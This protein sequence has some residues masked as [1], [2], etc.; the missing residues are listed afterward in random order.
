MK[1]KEFE[2][3]YEYQSKDSKNR[4]KESLFE[5]DNEDS[6]GNIVDKGLSFVPRAIRFKKAK[7]VMKRALN[8]YYL[9][10]VNLIRKFDRSMKVVGDKIEIKYKDLLENKISPLITEEKVEQTI[11]LLESFAEDLKQGQKTHLDKLNQSIETVLG[12]YTQSIEK[13]IES[14]GFVFNVELSEKGKGELSAKWNELVAIKKMKIDQKI[15]DLINSPGIGKINE[16]IS[17][18]EA[19]VEDKR[20][21]TGKHAL[22]YYVKTITPTGKNDYKVDVHLRTSGRRY[23][24]KEK[25]IIWD[26]DPNKLNLKNKGVSFYKSPDVGYSSYRASITGAQPEAYV[27]PFL[28]IHGNPTPKYG[29]TVK[30]QDAINI[31]TI[32]GQGTVDDTDLSGEERIIKKEN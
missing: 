5:A 32:G 10:A 11:R 13:R 3:L 9:K 15:A 18:A 21:T 29:T 2:S 30:I 24:L 23:K 28:Y 25:G 4:V 26:V 27:R 17:E 12:A 7:K 20:F 19:F 16:I 31:G 8:G 14:P 22:D 1:N 6:M